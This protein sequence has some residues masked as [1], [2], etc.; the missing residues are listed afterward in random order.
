[1][2]SNVLTILLAR[3]PQLEWLSLRHSDRSHCN[4]LSNILTDLFDQGKLLKLRYVYDTVMHYHTTQRFDWQFNSLYSRPTNSTKSLEILQ[5]MA[6]ERQEQQ[7]QNISTKSINQLLPSSSSSSNGSLLK[8]SDNVWHS[9]HNTFGLP[10]ITGAEQLIEVWP[11]PF[12]PPIFVKTVAKNSL[13][14]EDAAAIAAM[15]VGHRHYNYHV[16]R[17]RPSCWISM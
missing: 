6:S 9:S 5:A 16:P 2:T 10:S 4:E 14:M 3:C 1:M 13:V 8:Q 17:C 12:K 15:I 7:Q 11:M